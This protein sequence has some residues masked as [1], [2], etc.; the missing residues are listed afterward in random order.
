MKTFTYSGYRAEGQSVRG[1]VEALDRKDAREQ[2]VQQG[3]FAGK[4]TPA[5]A[6]VHSGSPWGGRGVSLALRAQVFREWALMLRAG[7]SLNQ[8]IELL[9]EASE[10]R[11][12]RNHLAEVRDAVREGGSLSQALARVANQ[13]RPFEQALLEVGERTGRLSESLLAVADYLDDD[14]SLRE[15]TLTAV[16]YPLLVLG[17]AVLIVG[18]TCTWLL[19]SF[20]ATLQEAGLEIPGW[21]GGLILAGRWGSILLLFGALAV[22]AGFRYLGPRMAQRQQL[23][24]RLELAASNLPGVRSYL[25]TMYVNRFCQALAILLDSGV[26]LLE[27]STLAAK[28]SGSRL[29][30]EQSDW[31][32][33]RIQEGDSLARVLSNVP[34]LQN[35]LPGW[36][37]AG[38]ESGALA[39]VLMQAGARAGRR[40]DRIRE[41]FL[42]LL[43][44][45]LIAL[46]GLFVMALS[47]G[48]LSPILS[49]NELLTQ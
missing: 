42:R 29:I 10:F 28:A 39:E 6:D 27:G 41:R 43:E 49:M 30:L 33:R 25:E 24:G 37:R 48:L 40:A 2:L 3:I 23:L 8:S 4:V 16:M 38:E 32:S 44:P 47:F 35:G 1:L 20:Q 26:P 22:V 46:I 36:L 5:G 31:I 12:I 14:L 45:I 11:K 34:W 18:I 13:W 7:H 15:K 9:L 19:P 21:A 17:V